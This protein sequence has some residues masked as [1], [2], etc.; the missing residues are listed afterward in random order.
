ME[1][2]DE[3]LARLRKLRREPTIPEMAAA[4]E[5]I[6][7]RALGRC[8]T[9]YLVEEGGKEATRSTPT[10]REHSGADK[11]FRITKERQNEK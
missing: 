7:Q 6:L 2:R 4:R 11:L 1:S 3:T 5:E 8:Q 9:E 10:G